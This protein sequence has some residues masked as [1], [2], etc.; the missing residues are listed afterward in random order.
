MKEYLCTTCQKIDIPARQPLN[1]KRK[2]MYPFWIVIAS[3][4]IIYFVAWYI[5]IIVFTL[6]ITSLIINDNIYRIKVCGYCG[7]NTLIE[8]KDTD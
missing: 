4:I 2:Y 6:T 5:G 3:F 7:H 8:T 1:F